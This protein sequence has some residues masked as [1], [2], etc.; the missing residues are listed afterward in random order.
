MELGL[1]RKTEMFLA[2]AHKIV[3]DREGQN[4]L[5]SFSGQPVTDVEIGSRKGFLPIFLW[6]AEELHKRVAGYSFDVDYF[7]Q[8]ETISGFDVKL[9]RFSGSASELF[10][11][12][13]ES[14]DDAY[15]T[16][17]RNKASNKI[18]DID[19]LFDRFNRA[20]RVMLPADTS[21]STP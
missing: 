17:P 7:R 8:S 12:L 1:L 16:L 15:K 20:M 14:L 9:D 18:P 10:L 19:Y 2:A 3:A 11:F 13:V 21:K 6:R 4:S 5:F